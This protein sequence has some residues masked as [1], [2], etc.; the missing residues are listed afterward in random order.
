MCSCCDAGTCLYFPTCPLSIAH[1]LS[2]D[3][4][5]K[6]FLQLLNFSESFCVWHSLQNCCKRNL[7][8]FHIIIFHPKKCCKGAVKWCW[9]YYC[10]VI[11]TGVL[12]LGKKVFLCYQNFFF[13]KE[14]N[15][16]VWPLVTACFSLRW[17]KYLLASVHCRRLHPPGRKAVEA[18]LLGSVSK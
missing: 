16:I 11:L 9:V 3:R 10:L 7:T 1:S 13:F 5:T 18:H 6:T 2:P 4:K 12:D 14:C 8:F 15:Y 17:R